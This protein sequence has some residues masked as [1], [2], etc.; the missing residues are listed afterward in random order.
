MRIGH[1]NGAQPPPLSDMHEEER[2]YLI[3][4][5]EVATS[6]DCDGCLIVMRQGDVADLMCSSCGAIVDTVP[7][8]RTGLRLMELASDEIC[9]ACCPHCG[10]PNVFRGYTVIEAFVCRECGEGVN[11]ERPVQ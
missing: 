11:M 7:I 5:H 2:G 6:A 4:R 9:S 8:D 1:G 3:V 10:A